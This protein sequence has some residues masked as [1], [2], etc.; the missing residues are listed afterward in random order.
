MPGTPPRRDLLGLAHAAH[1]VILHVL[2]DPAGTGGEPG[3]DA[4]RFDRP[5]AM[6]LARTPRAPYSSA[7]PLTS[8]CT[9][10]LA[11]P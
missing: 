8:D 5:G 7:S 10:A 2:V 11:A 3:E 4:G 9:P 6:A 1:G